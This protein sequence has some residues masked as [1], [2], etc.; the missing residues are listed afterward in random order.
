MY[1]VRVLTA[2]ILVLALA[3]TATFAASVHLKKKPPLTFNDDTQTS[4]VATGPLTLTVSGALAGLGNGDV[5][6]TLS[7]TAQ[8]TATCTNPGNGIHQ[9]PG[10]NPALV[11]LGGTRGF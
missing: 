2:L 11:V 3:A 1:K 6:I 5:A 7:A 8:P 9:P 4:P 10:H